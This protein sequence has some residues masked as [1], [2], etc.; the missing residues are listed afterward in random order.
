M[1]KLL[2]W[3]LAAILICGASVFASCTNNISDNPVTPIEPVEPVEPD[4]NVTKMII[5]RWIVADKDGQPVMTNEK[6]VLNFISPT[7]VYVSA[8]IVNNPNIGELWADL[9]EN[10]VVIS[11]N[12]VTVTGQIDEHMT[13]I[14][15]YTVTDINATEF[16]AQLKAAVM[17]DGTIVDSGE[18]LSLRFAKVKVDYSASIL[19]LWEG[20]STGAEGSEFDD[21][22]SHRWEYAVDGTYR[23]YEKVDGLWQQS[24]NA[25]NEYFVAGNLLCT[26]WEDNGVENREWWE[27]E[28]IDYDE[29]KWTALRQKEDGTTYT[30][31]FEMKKV[32]E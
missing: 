8:S 5:G 30:A 28:S 16:Y 2:N 17:V 21:G 13:V 27:I 4:L 14:E 23:Y 32:I 3:I 18:G 12:K 25:M 19:G 10:D 20:Y 1:K 15:E 9:L 26:R 31:T 22:G 11:G 6:V 29:M 24:A 7:K